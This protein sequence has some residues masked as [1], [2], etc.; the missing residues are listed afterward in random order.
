MVPITVE[1]GVVR[2]IERGVDA[3]LDQWTDAVRPKLI[4][5]RFGVI[6]TVGS[7]TP[8]V[9]RVSAGDLRADLEVGFL[10][11]RIVNV[12]DV[13]CFD[14]NE[15]GDFECPDAVVSTIGVVAAGLI[16][17]EASRVEA[18]WPE[19]FSTEASRNARQSVIGRRSNQIRNTVK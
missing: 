17:V 19:R 5:E 9:A 13:Q 8:Q 11:G 18:T 1:A 3:V 4:T 12:G 15:S 2:V 10:G 16:T 14:V 7:Q 6:A